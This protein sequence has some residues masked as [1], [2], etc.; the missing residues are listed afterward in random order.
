MIE[1]YYFMLF[2]RYNLAV[3]SSFKATKCKL[4]TPLCSNVYNI[5][6]SY[7]K[8]YSHLLTNSKAWLIPLYCSVD[9]FGIASLRQLRT[10][11]FI[12]SGGLWNGEIWS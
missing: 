7:R 6:L 10:L 3:K 9:Q 5:L 12:S 11:D 2:T 8:N 1:C 4:N